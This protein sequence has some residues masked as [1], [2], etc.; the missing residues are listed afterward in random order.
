MSTQEDYKIVER[1]KEVM[2][3][4]PLY[5]PKAL[6]D[7]GAVD[8]LAI[9]DGYQAKITGPEMVEIDNPD[10]PLMFNIKN[11]QNMMK[12][13]YRA[14]MERGG[15]IQGRELAR[16]QFEALFKDNEQN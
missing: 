10:S 15:E 1:E 16:Q 5:V 14:I 3:L 9:N 13:K 11:I 7:A 8:Q 2:I 4:V 12:E 6:Y